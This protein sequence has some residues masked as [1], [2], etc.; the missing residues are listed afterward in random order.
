MLPGRKLADEFKQEPTAVVLRLLQTEERPLSCGD[1]KKALQAQRIPKNEVDGSWTRVQKR[2][3]AHN[4]V[5]TQGAGSRTTYRWASDRPAESALAA[6][7]RIVKGRLPAD[8]KVILAAIVRTAL[9]K[10]AV[11]PAAVGSSPRP[12]PEERAR[13]RQREIDGM[14]SLAELAA[15]VEELTINEAE[16]DVM[17]HRVRARLKRSGLE[18][19]DRAGEE[20]TFDRKRHKPI[21]GSVT[22][23]ATVVVVR[24]GYVWKAPTED[25]LIGKAVVIE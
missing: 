23:G 5:V 6:F 18:P 14:R 13:E 17:I 10:G 22:D 9:E 24:P 11:S 12:D 7:E 4:D 19:I 2:L 15:E 21:G 3:R 1:I 25:V 20:T 16:A 8:T